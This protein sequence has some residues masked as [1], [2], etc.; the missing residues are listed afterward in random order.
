MPSS[1]RFIFVSATIKRFSCVTFLVQ[2]YGVF[3]SNGT[4][5]GGQVHKHCL[6]ESF[7]ACAL[8]PSLAPTSL[9]CRK[10]PSSGLWPTSRITV[11]SSSRLVTGACVQALVGACCSGLIRLVF[12]LPGPHHWHEGGAW[13]ESMGCRCMRAAAI[14]IIT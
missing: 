1:A 13:I 14:V 3:V 12:Q 5:G 4:Q 11:W 8:P 7:F 9:M 2:P 6:T 10:H